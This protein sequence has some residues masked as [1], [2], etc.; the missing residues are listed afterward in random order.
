MGSQSHL[1]ED[2]GVDGAEDSFAFVSGSERDAGCGEDK[3]AAKRESVAGSESNCE[4]GTQR[5]ESLADFLSFMGSV[6]K[7]F[8]K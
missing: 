5:L 8:R 4:I 6:E 3:M 1:V 2:G 7:P